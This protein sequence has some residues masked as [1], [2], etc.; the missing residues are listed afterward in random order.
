MNLL[1]LKI[2]KYNYNNIILFLIKFIYINLVRPL[3]LTYIWVVTFNKVALVQSHVEPSFN[4][5]NSVHNLLNVLITIRFIML[6]LILV[7]WLLSK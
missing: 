7:L 5:T 6:R 4:R 1:Y 2:I 3:G